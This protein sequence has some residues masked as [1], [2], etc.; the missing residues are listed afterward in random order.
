VR[1]AVLALALLA[2][3]CREPP[4]S[5]GTRPAAAEPAP[6][7]PFPE[8]DVTVRNPGACVDAFDPQ[9]D[10][11]PDKAVPRFAAGFTI[12]YG[13]HFKVLT[14]TTPAASYRYLLVQ[15]GTPVPGGFDDALVVRIPV[16]TLVTTSTTELAH[17]VALGLVD[18]L[19]GHDEMDYVVSPE[20]RR[21]FAEGRLVEVGDESRLDLERLVEVAPDLVLAT[22]VEGAGVDKLSKLGDVG[23]AVAQVPSFLETTPLGRAEWMLY[24]AAFFNREAR[25]A[26]LLDEIARRYLEL[27]ALGRAASSRPAVLVGAPLGDTWYMPGGRSFMAHLVDDAGGRYLWADEAS[28]GSLPLALE[29]VFER[30]LGADVWLHP[31][32]A[33]RLA[34]LA[35]L[36]ERFTRLPVFAAGAVWANDARTNALG[37]NAVGGNDY[38]ETG[39]ARPDLVLADLLKILHPELVPEVELTFH[40]RLE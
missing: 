24:T 18:R 16:R 28:P 26:A 15:C 19:V 36:D 31:G 37:G 8:V 10:L 12:E 27:A 11:F 17:L 35:A 30:A 33:S 6:P 38:W 21:R 9:R 40:R 1:S 2:L 22:A 4:A 5:T 34:D 32:T 7:I 13:R 3:A 14:V 23:L 20:I 25:A 29:A 39:S